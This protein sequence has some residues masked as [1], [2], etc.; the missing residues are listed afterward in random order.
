MD[1]I[2]VGI[3][4]SGFS[5]MAHV[6]AL[7][8]IPCVEVW[9]IAASSLEKSREVAGKMRIPH[10][11][12]SVDELIQ[13]PDIQAVHN[14]TP[15]RLHFELNKKILLA[16]KHLMSEKPLAVSSAE[17]AELVELAAQADVVSGVC[18]NYRHYPMVSQVKEM[19]QSGEQGRINL[20]YGGYLQDWLLFDTDYSWRLEPD[21]NGPSR[22]I[23]DI[24]SHWCDTVQYVLDKKIVEVFADL[25]TVHLVRKKAKQKVTTFSTNGDVEREDVRISS[26]DYGS[27]LLHFEDGVQGVFAVSQVSAGRKNHLHF[28]VATDRSSFSWDQEKPNQ[29]WVGQRDQASEAWSTDPGLLSPKSAELTHYPGGHHEGWPDGLKNLCIDFYKRVLDREHDRSFATIE[30]GH[31]IMLLIEAILKSHQ[32]KRWVQIENEVRT[33]IAL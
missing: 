23:A 29:L 2:K 11:Y 33:E 18:F 15:N 9:G 1:T 10:A 6:E 12:A 19:L 25:K 21:K 17:S 27:V 14:C 32:E 13:D 3:A 26:E 24:G 5:A 22:A 8:R 20:V 16:G 4:G 31:R 7:R 28:E 30:D